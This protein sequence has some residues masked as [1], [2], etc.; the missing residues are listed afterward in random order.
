MNRLAACLLLGFT[1]AL[2]FLAPEAHARDMQG[3]LGIG[4]NNEWVTG[5]SA[6]SLSVKYGFTRDL[7]MEVTA[8]VATTSPIALNA[9]AKFFKNIFYETSL[10]FYFMIGAGLVSLSGNTGAEF[11]TGFG[12]E[13][14]I[15]GIESLGL[16]IETGAE[17][18]NAG[19]GFV[20][21]TLGVSFLAAGVHFYF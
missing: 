7:A 11:L 14:F 5:S 18:D 10:N 15:P 9:G 3:R 16:S 21:R 19:G 12:A 4:F 17:V 2:M 13:F 8:G 20:V 1:S 6:P